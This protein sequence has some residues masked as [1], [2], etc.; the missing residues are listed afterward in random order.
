M[1]YKL[2]QSSKFSHIEINV[3]SKWKKQRIH[4]YLLPSFSLKTN[5]VKAKNKENP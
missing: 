4:N 2:M 3:L 5:L 1:I